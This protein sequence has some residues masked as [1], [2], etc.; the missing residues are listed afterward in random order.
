M[1]N[2]LKDII[3]GL[4]ITI[5]FFTIIPMP[6]V[7]WKNSRMKYMPIFYPVVG[8]IIGLILANTYNFFRYNYP[9]MST[10]TVSVIIVVLCIILTGGLHIDGLMDTTDAHLS[11]RPREEKLRILKDSHVGA[12]SVV[13][14]VV[15]IILKITIL[16]ELFRISGMFDFLVFVPVISRFLVGFMLI[17]S[18]FAT[19]DGLAKMYGSLATKF[20]RSIQFILMILVFALIGVIHNNMFFVMGGVFI[21]FTYYKYIFCYREFG[22]ITGD[23]SG[24]FL[25]LSEL[26]MFF[27]ILLTKIHY[28]R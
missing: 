20:I 22:G 8:I 16:N 24:A 14:F 6:R 28:L 2:K 5:S 26:L 10:F 17:N 18:K 11:R 15:F 19:N 4:I 13:W 7:E 3:G 21:F 27:L 23:L 12:Y 25:E 9:E 1:K